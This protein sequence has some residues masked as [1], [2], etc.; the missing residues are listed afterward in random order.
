MLSLANTLFQESTEV[1][2]I[3]GSSSGVPTLGE[4]QKHYGAHFSV[5]QINYWVGNFGECA[6][7]F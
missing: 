7:L 1:L 3:V 4:K 5:L 6:G 2:P